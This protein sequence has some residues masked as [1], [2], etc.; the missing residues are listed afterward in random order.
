[1]ASDDRS[2][3]DDRYG[4]DEKTN[5]NQLASVAGRFVPQW[6]VRRGVDVR[7][8]TD[9]ERYERGEPVEIVV[10]LRNRLPVPVTVETPQRRL[11]GWTV[12]GHL[13]ASDEPRYDDGQGG[14][15]SFRGRERKRLTRRW[16]GRIKHVGE[17]TRWDQATGDL[18]ITA[19]LAV[20]DDR[21]VDATTIRIE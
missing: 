15:M 18:E 5:P 12:E 20:E 9:R 13:E 10:E 11:W 17:R 2:G 4:L 3:A 21:P 1:M 6:L 8:T 19:F 7:V 14:T 16:D